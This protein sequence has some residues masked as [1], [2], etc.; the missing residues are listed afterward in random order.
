LSEA[1][2]GAA[3]DPA[4]PQPLW[5]HPAFLW[6]LALGFALLL[7]HSLWWSSISTG[8]VDLEF[9]VAEL[10][11]RETIE[12]AA[13]F[14]V[15]VFGF[16]GGVLASFSPCILPLIPLNIA[17]IGAA[18]ATGWRAADLSG[19]FVLGAALALAVLGL[20]GDL[21]GFLLIDQ[22]GPVLLIAGI[23]MLY[24]A[25][26]ALELVPIPF[27]GRSAGAG[28]RLGPIAAGAAFSVVT[29]PCASP[30]LAAVLTASSAQSVPGLTVA[31]MVSFAVG[32][33]A[34]V[35]VGGVFGGSLVRRLRGRSFD[36]PRAAAAA[37]LV[38]MG[39]V[40]VATGITWF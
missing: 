2:S 32:Y 26:A 15:P 14:L 27:A 4:L 28:R 12:H 29:T 37:L 13:W 20:A 8:L 6:P 30:I 17:A 23:A 31:S 24:F 25:L 39:G 38:V 10:L 18:D 22:R 35:F 16:A 36:A 1:V 19:R 3:G 33:T 7:S 9:A 34:L 21:A 5:R 11:P 40:F